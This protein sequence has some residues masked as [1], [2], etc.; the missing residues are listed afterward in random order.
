MWLDCIW[1]QGPRGSRFRFLQEKA[2]GWGLGREVQP[3]LCLCLIHSPPLTDSFSRA[4]SPS[5]H[6]I[7]LYFTLLITFISLFFLF[8]SS[9][10]TL[11]SSSLI[12]L[13]SPSSPSCIRLA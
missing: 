4:Q 10:F 1:I 8:P 3:K 6:I 11:H 13:C 5:F 9:F 12:P 2:G 7:F